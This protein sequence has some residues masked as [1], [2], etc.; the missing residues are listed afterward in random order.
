MSR[1]GGEQAHN[2]PSREGAILAE[3]Q[4]TTALG[5]FPH[6]LGSE[7]TQAVLCPWITVQRETSFRKNPPILTVAAAALPPPQAA[8]PSSSLPCRPYVFPF[9]NLQRR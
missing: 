7:P 1:Q 6:E 2:R 9:P 3:D 4:S 8:L 5:A